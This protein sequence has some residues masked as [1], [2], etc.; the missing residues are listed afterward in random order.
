[1]LKS[2]IGCLGYLA[3]TIVVPILAVGAMITVVLLGTSEELCFDRRPWWGPPESGTNE[4]CS[5][6]MYQRH[7]AGYGWLGP[8]PK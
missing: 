1:M 8:G 4:E 6:H 5:G 3:L 7:E 2:S